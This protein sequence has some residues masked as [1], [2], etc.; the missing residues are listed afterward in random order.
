MISNSLDKL[1]QDYYWHQ[2]R[3]TVVVLPDQIINHHELV[4]I[5]IFVEKQKVSWGII[6]NILQ[7]HT[8][9]FSDFLY[10]VL[11]M[12]PPYHMSNFLKY[13]IPAS[14]FHITRY[15]SLYYVN[16]NI[17]S[18]HHVNLPSHPFHRSPALVC[19]LCWGYNPRDLA[20]KS[21]PSLVHPG[22]TRSQVHR[23]LCNTFSG[24]KMI[25]YMYHWQQ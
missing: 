14:W 7:E 10:L 12:L 13:E 8:N 9:P 5:N 11:N 2:S 23:E 20:S 4:L 18:F 16:V 1:L 24:E 22:V 6:I 21:P 15:S 17:S 3:K 19:Y 25:L